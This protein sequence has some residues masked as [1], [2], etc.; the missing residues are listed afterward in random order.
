MQ[1]RKNFNNENFPNYG[2]NFRVDKFSQLTVDGYIYAR[3]PGAYIVYMHIK[4]C[5]CKLLCYLCSAKYIQPL[6]NY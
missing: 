5:S 3:A 2:K 6:I 4:S 1:L